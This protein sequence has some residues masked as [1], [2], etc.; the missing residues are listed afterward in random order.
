[1]PSKSLLKLTSR[2]FTAKIDKLV[3]GG[4]GITNFN[5]LK[6]FV[7][8]AA[9]QDE[10][11]LTLVEEKKHYGI[12][13]IEKIVKPSPVRKEPSCRYFTKC[14]GCDWQHLSYEGQL[15]AKKDIVKEIFLRL[16]QFNW[17]NSI[18]I[19]PSTPFNYRNK[20]QFPIAELPLRIGYFARQTHN[21]VDIETCQLHIPIFD[22]IL[23]KIRKSIFSSQETVYN[24][25][26]HTG[27]L[28]HIILRAGI[29]TNEVLI[30]FVTRERKLSQKVYKG[31]AEEFPH[32]VGICQN[33]NSDKTN[34]IL[35]PETKILYGQEYYH[36][37]ILD[38]TF[39]VSATSFFQVNTSQIPNL[40][41]ILRNYL[42]NNTRYVLDLYC[43]VGV[44]SIAISD[45]AQKIW[46]IEINPTAIADAQKNRQLN[47]TNN[48]EFIAQ[49]VKNVLSD[50][51]NQNIDT[52]I[53]DP[54]R[55]GCDT[56]VLQK[57][58]M[59]KPQTIIYV[60]CNPTTFVRDLVFLN[61]YNYQLNDCVL[62]DMF[63]QTYHI[64]LIAKILHHD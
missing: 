35:G 2:Q 59:L 12:A 55:K 58:V 43:G 37:K 14:G 30:I 64:E 45:L 16:G 20:S 26:E 40:I 44:L 42:D 1:M 18:S 54:P 9:P 5:E 62:I 11:K 6:I 25:K 33:I 24:E 36:E 53:V 38:W 52:V 31:V 39:Q 56:E 60:S 19:I 15:T 29:N 41:R 7:P 3:Y 51:R 28:R 8:Y 50:F 23:K 63:P 48:I 57:I 49:D 32:I 47:N 46:S 13:K 21:V 27:N 22:Q 4:Y 34:R 10:L 17:P 61:K